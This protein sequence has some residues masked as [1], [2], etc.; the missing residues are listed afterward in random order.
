MVVEVTGMDLCSGDE[1][2]VK[3]NL[4]FDSEREALAA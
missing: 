4:N 3:A 2:S 1:I